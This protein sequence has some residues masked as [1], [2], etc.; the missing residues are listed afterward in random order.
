[1]F[2]GNIY[3][4]RDEGPMKILL[5]L[6]SMEVLEGVPEYGSKLLPSLRGKKGLLS[7]NKVIV[8]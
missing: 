1:M 6:G 8:L 3:T 2:I 5:R 4:V 7:R